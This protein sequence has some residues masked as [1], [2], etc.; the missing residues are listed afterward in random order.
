[1]YVNQKKL[2]ED[3]VLEKTTF[4]TFE[5][6]VIKSASCCNLSEVIYRDYGARS[7]FS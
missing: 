4:G 1:M 6:Y 5:G 2:I 3:L 7:L